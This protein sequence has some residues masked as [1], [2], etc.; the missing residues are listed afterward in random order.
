MATASRRRKGKT[1]VVVWTMRSPYVFVGGK[2]EV[3][4]TGAR[5]ALSWDGRSWDEVDRDLDRLFRA[6]GARR[7]TCIT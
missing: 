1:G 7:V 5:F 2:L 3:E 6:R 4:G